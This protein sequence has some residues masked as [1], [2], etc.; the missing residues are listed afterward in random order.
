[1]VILRFPSVRQAEPIL[2]EQRDELSNRVT[3]YQRLMKKL[4]NN[5]KLKRLLMP[6]SGN[7]FELANFKIML[8]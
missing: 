1:M 4:K 8:Y 6:E 7:K 3:Q 2:R 5:Y